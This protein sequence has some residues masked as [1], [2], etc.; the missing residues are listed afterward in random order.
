MQHKLI[1]S[2]RQMRLVSEAFPSPIKLLHRALQLIP[3]GDCHLGAG[4][5]GV[6]ECVLQVCGLLHLLC[7]LLSQQWCKDAIVA[8][9]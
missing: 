1:A 4:P 9:S 6:V 3:W 8:V 7:A 5:S 2:K